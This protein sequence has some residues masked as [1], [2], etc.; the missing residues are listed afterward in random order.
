[1]RVLF[2]F[3]VTLLYSAGI[4]CGCYI[5]VLDTMSCLDMPQISD[6]REGLKSL[7]SGFCADKEERVSVLGVFDLWL[8]EATAQNLTLS[9]LC[10]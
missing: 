8:L 4:F 5:I 3:N 10:Q 1:M 9:A 6:E 7:L 2:A